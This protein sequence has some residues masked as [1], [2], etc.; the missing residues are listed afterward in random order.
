VSREEDLER[1]RAAAAQAALDGNYKA[2]AGIQAIHDTI[3]N[4]RDKGK[5]KDKGN[6]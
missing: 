2:A 5:E 1:M 6:K 3:K 4:D